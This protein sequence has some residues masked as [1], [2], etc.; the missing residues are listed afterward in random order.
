MTTTALTSRKV[1]LPLATLLAAGAVAVGSGA[2][3]TSTTDASVAVTSGTLLHT[4][5]RDG[6]VLTLSNIKP[7]DTMS[8]TVVVENTGSIDSTLDLA[9]SGVSSDFTDYLEITV[10]ENGTTLYSGPFNDLAISQTD[11]DFPASDNPATAGVDEDNATYDFEVTL[12]N[13]TTG[14]PSEQNADQGAGAGATFTWTQTQ[15]DGE[16]LVETWVPG[17]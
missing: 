17:A 1:L 4:N 15:V 6:A 5:T 10:S 14:T 8:G 12:V 11:I 7:G 9:V 2:T 3:W 16:T 13:N